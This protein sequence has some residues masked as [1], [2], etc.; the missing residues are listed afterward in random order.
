MTQ[1]WTAPAWLVLVAA[2]VLVLLLVAVVVALA[3]FATRARA[4]RRLAT[5][6]AELREQLAGI[7]RRLDH[8]TDEQAAGARGAGPGEQRADHERL[9]APY[10]I[11]R[12]GD[13]PVPTEVEP[14]PV[15]P[16]GV[17]ADIVL[18]E[19]VVQTAS[20]LHGLRRALSPEVRNRARFAAR[21]EVKR[22]RKS[23]RA[24]QRVAMREWQARQRTEQTDTSTDAA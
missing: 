8:Q 24:E 23:R 20:I 15:V 4:T 10:V 1:E 3:Q 12:L 5:E 9:V 7:E 6:T 22:S 18:R 2:G 16:A 13:E 14:A 17:F 11:T 21:Q 19:S